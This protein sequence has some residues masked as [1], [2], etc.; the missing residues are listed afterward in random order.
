MVSDQ[1]AIQWA[2]QYSGLG[3][4]ELPAAQQSK[5]WP[6]EEMPEDIRGHSKSIREMNGLPLAFWDRAG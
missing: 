4:S 6:S 2:I 3:R 5:P 1:S